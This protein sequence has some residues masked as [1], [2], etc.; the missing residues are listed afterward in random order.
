MVN[1]LVNFFIII[2]F[3][4]ISVD[5]VQ[6]SVGGFDLDFTANNGIKCQKNGIELNLKLDSVTTGNIYIWRIEDGDIWNND[7]LVDTIS[8]SVMIPCKRYSNFEAGVQRA[9]DEHFINPNIVYHYRIRTSNVAPVGTDA[10]WSAHP[11]GGNGQA[12]YDPTVTIPDDGIE[13]WQIP[14]GNYCQIKLNLID[15][16]CDVNELP[17]IKLNFEKINGGETLG[18]VYSI[19]RKFQKENIYSQLTV[20]DSL[21][22]LSYN[23]ENQIK[24]TS[25]DYLNM[26]D[27]SDE[28][29]H[30]VKYI[31]DYN[32]NYSNIVELNM[33][34]C[35]PKVLSVSTLC[36]NS[37]G[38][39]RVEIRTQPTI[40]AKQYDFY[41]ASSTDPSVD[42]S[43]NKEEHELTQEVDLV[44]NLNFLTILPLCT[45]GD[46]YS[47]ITCND[48]YQIKAQVLDADAQISSEEIAIQN[49]NNFSCN[50]SADPIGPP[51]ITSSDTECNGTDSRIK[52]KWDATQNVLYYTV[53]RYSGVD[54]NSDGLGD[55]INLYDTFV[56]E[57]IDSNVEFNKTYEYHIEAIGIK[58]G[59]S[60][61]GTVTSGVITSATCSA[62]NKPTVSFGRGCA[63]GVPYVDVKWLDVP[64]T[65]N[66][67]IKR[68]TDNFSLGTVNDITFLKKDDL[69]GA[70]TGEVYGYT[71][72]AKNG[73]SEAVSDITNST[74]IDC[75]PTQITNGSSVPGCDMTMS[76][77]HNPTIKVS[78]STD[79]ANTTAYKI[80]REDD[81]SGV[82]NLVNTINDVGIH[83][84]T[85]TDFL[86]PDDIDKDYDY[87]VVAVGY[88]DQ[89]A[90]STND[91]SVTTLFCSA[92]DDF[93]LT[94]VSRCYNNIYPSIQFDWDSDLREEYFRFE[95]DDFGDLISFNTEE[96]YKIRR[97][98]GNYLKFDGGHYLELK[99]CLGTPN[100][101]SVEFWFYD[102][103]K[104]ANTYLFDDRDTS[105]VGG[106]L[107][108][109]HNGAGNIN[110]SD[111]VKINSDKWYANQW[112][113]IV[114][115]AK[116]GESCIYINGGNRVCSA[117]PGK[118]SFDSFRFG[119]R[120]SKDHFFNGNIDDARIYD[121]ILSAAEVKNYYEGIH[122]NTGLIAYYTFDEGD[123]TIAY[124]SY[125]KSKARLRDSSGNLDSFWGNEAT[126]SYDDGDIYDYEVS[127]INPVDTTK[128][129]VNNITIDDSLCDLVVP[130]LYLE[131]ECISDT[132]ARFF[133]SSSPYY[134]IDEVQ[135]SI[136]GNFTP[137]YSA[138]DSVFDNRGYVDDNG[139][140]N[141]QADSTTGGTIRKYKIKTK[142]G[143]VGSIWS[144]EFEIKV[145]NCVKPNPSDLSS[146]GGFQCSGV[147][148]QEASVDLAWSTTTNTIT[149]EL[150][151]KKSTDVLFDLLP[152]KTFS[153]GTN[154]WTDTYNLVIGE[155]YDYMIFGVGPSGAGETDANSYLNNVR[156]GYCDVVATTLDLSLDCEGASAVIRFG[157]LDN[158]S[159]NVDK[160][161]LQSWDGSSFVDEMIVASNT[162]PGVGLWATSTVFTGLADNTNFKLRIK[163]VGMNGSSVTSNEESITTLFCST[164][165]TKPL[166]LTIVSKTCNGK[167]LPE[168]ALNWDDSVA[169][170]SYDVFRMNSSDNVVSTS[171]VARSE[172]TEKVDYVLRLRGNDILRTDNTIDDALDIED[173]VTISYWV[174][175]TGTSVPNDKYFYVRKYNSYGIMH[176]KFL[177]R[178]SVKV[179]DVL[180]ETDNVTLGS[181]S[182]NYVVGTYS[183]YNRT[184]KFYV[185]GEYV[186]T[187]NIPIDGSFCDYK[188]KVVANENFK[189]YSDSTGNRDVYIEDL[190]VYKRALDG[191]PSMNNNCIS[192][193]DNEV[194][195]L[196][197]REYNNEVGLVASWDF[198]DGLGSAIVTDIAGNNTDLNFGIYDTADKNEMING[199]W[200]LAKDSGL[201]VGVNN[202][203]DSKK[204]YTYK[205]MAKGVGTKSVLSDATSLGTFTCPSAVVG[206]DFTLNQICSSAH[207]PFLIF[208][209]PVE[210]DYIME[211][212]ASSSVYHVEANPYSLINSNGYLKNWLFLDKSLDATGKNVDHEYITDIHE[213]EVAPR[214]GDSFVYN[215][216]IY[217]WN[218]KYVNSVNYN[219]PK[220][221]INNIYANDLDYT[222]FYA[223]TYFYNS[224]PESTDNKFQVTHDD[225]MQI[226][227]NEESIYN[228]NN[229]QSSLRDIGNLTFKQGINIVVVKIKNNTG[230][231]Y[232]SLKPVY[233]D[234]STV[235]KFS[236]GFNTTENF[237][238]TYKISKVGPV[239]N[240]SSDIS[241]TFTANT[242]QP[243]KPTITDLN[244]VCDTDTGDNTVTIKWDE[245]TYPDNTSYFKVHRQKISDNSIYSSNGIYN[246][247][248]PGGKYVY[249][250]SSVLNEDYDYWVTAYRAGISTSSNA[251]S[252]TPLACYAVPTITSFKATSSCVSM[253]AA[254][255]VQLTVEGVTDVL[256]YEIFR[257][258]D[259]WTSSSSVGIYAGDAQ[260]VDDTSFVESDIGSSFEYKIVLNGM[261]ADD[262]AYHIS[263]M[264]DI[265]AEVLN[266]SLMPPIAPNLFDINIGNVV[267]SGLNVQ[268]GNITWTDSGNE[269]A[270]YIQRATSTEGGDALDSDFETVMPISNTDNSDLNFT[271]SLAYHIEDGN[272]YEYRI[273]AYNANG[274]TTS[275]T[276]KIYV[277][278]SVPG[279]Y[280]IISANPI[281]Q[282]N[283]DIFV[284]VEFQV[285]EITKNAEL[286]SAIT[287]TELSSGV[288]GYESS[289]I[290]DL[291]FEISKFK[292][293]ALSIVL[294][295]YYNININTDSNNANGYIKDFGAGKYIHDC[296]GTFPGSCTYYATGD[297]TDC[298]HVFIDKKPSAFARYYS[299]KAYSEA[300]KS[301][302][303]GGDDKPATFSASSTASYVLPKWEETQP[304]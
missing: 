26:F 166:N 82:F 296:K 88:N 208:S 153:F 33:P 246:E 64:N 90:T 173:E 98:F 95:E 194:C 241:K 127:A 240:T 130:I 53:Y 225:G 32:G 215:T 155:E 190:K 115:T 34:A 165:P 248:L 61:F 101:S 277:P 102:S 186:A 180:H 199:P 297:F 235:T 83:F 19:E 86:Y 161:I 261:V 56:N 189:I 17:F 253:V 93:T 1:K 227:L 257:S 174:K 293:P 226:Y 178:F 168:V 67:I 254:S 132:R 273:Q 131:Y 73:I 7:S 22:L 169:A 214:F 179:N 236:N 282:S 75:G 117:G 268:I 218:E 142:K 45:S 148:S 301:L 284:E 210:H 247:S 31:V 205:V 283:G 245:D 51:N 185:N 144:D 222:A 119:S 158:Y 36:S 126:N 237:F 290:D 304:E 183:S 15:N 92:P 256:T 276:K 49:N 231:V 11:D 112:N 234:G 62:P 272:W 103:N 275:A 143:V 203:I 25:N 172:Y 108:K 181:G 80:Y 258:D 206:G 105:G 16:G 76:A 170:Y 266:C 271:D 140:A 192:N 55:T 212:R 156:I 121:R 250:D 94:T 217:T 171:S 209:W 291:Q 177:G 255:L 280:R 91:L 104:N 295:G 123:G 197:K 292:N 8:C 133:A 3:F 202:Y 27:R 12:G 163:S 74:V 175:F 289:V 29:R 207:E 122:N 107:I 264:S 260:F 303:N 302:S 265:K 216:I 78:W 167:N 71:V 135:Y 278:L 145:P 63:L 139:G 193:P 128:S 129:S 141:Y 35:E 221:L 298:C 150:Y 285:P 30:K 160:Y 38:Q 14:G 287:T 239:G 262:P 77:P 267:S 263:M 66:Y 147:H 230:A 10:E 58:P 99:S 57:F 2:F 249:A 187:K 288:P 286:S 109:S 228:N 152:Y 48:N 251:W 137:W 219:E 238:E 4:L 281:E 200:V 184:L 68:V 299:I 223:F 125:G 162:V 97:A 116:V 96:N 9:G 69:V 79:S 229:L 154:S 89:Y 118:L 44:D 28:Y 191:P 196:Y 46:N 195:D 188:I 87:K 274:T 41:R 124:S 39:H 134:G 72:T 111:A 81:N 43:V 242:C 224:S 243:E 54:D 159:Y 270:Y 232:F 13:N 300:C 149:Y 138:G 269:I 42:E 37:G 50:S 136:D 59:T 213:N 146:S 18:D 279:P 40:G 84:W 114:I 24:I 233:G 6:A 60:L 198:N 182:W 110:Y 47:S 100:E 85:D 252:I 21:D 151:R 120:Y 70:T 106:Y 244:S 157:I 65:D 294:I 220:I 201:T 204:N 5:V 20:Q 211:F 23:F 259:N 113:H 176:N 164:A 52:L